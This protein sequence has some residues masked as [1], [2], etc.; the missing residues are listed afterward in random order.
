MIDLGVVL[1]H[2]RVR[3]IYQIKW[4]EK[5]IQSIF[6][7]TY[8]SFD[9]IE[10]NYHTEQEEFLKNQ[11]ASLSPPEWNGRWT[12]IYQPCSDHSVAMNVC[13]DYVKNQPSSSGQSYVAIANVNLDDYYDSHRFELQ[14]QQIRLGTH[15]VFSY[16]SHVREFHFPPLFDSVDQVVFKIEPK[17]DDRDHLVRQLRHTNI[18]AHP[19]VMLATSAWRSHEDICYRQEIPCEDWK[20]WQRMMR[21]PEIKCVILPRHLLFY[22]IHD[23]QISAVPR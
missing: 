7:Q 23:K 11:F 9:I 18:I 8:Q 20:L 12:T 19:V 5:C 13:F 17:V 6:R 4:I 16:F 2:K 21:H 14:M 3:N 15:L 1:F 10:L 22:R